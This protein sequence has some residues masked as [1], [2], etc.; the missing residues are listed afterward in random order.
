LV[1]LGLSE[2]AAA[3]T[4]W[5]LAAAS[6]GLAVVVRNFAWPVVALL[7]PLFGMA[8]VYFLVFV[9]GVKVYAPLDNA[10]EGRGRAILPTLADFG[11]K[12]RIFEVLS[13]LVIIVL[14]YYAAF[15]LRFDSDITIYY[16]H[17]IRSLPLVIVCQLAAFL[18]IG[19]YKG[20]WRYTSMSDVA[21][22]V[23]CTAG[24]WV[25]ST[26]MVVFFYRFDGWSRGVLVMD[27]VLLFLGVTGTRVAFRV[28]RNWM[29]RLKPPANAKRVL[30]YGAGDGGE[31]LLRE[32]IN[33]RELGLHPVG[34]VDDDPQKQG[35]MIHGVKVLGPLERLQTLASEQQVD[36]LVIS[37]GKLEAER[38]EMVSQL[39]AN[40]GVHCRR[41]RISLD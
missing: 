36:E 2:R 31:L 1:A 15:L 9:A 32:L 24:A 6:G 26:L 16:T 30:I 29:L 40:A 37:T 19:Q 38:S 27:G 34:F 18:I 23:K 41:M 22:F 7:V 33:N 5:A 13:D 21:S 12:R 20:L 11:Y 35:R 39:C 17:F 8:V 28:L 3:L 4:L 14:A 25:S 10:D